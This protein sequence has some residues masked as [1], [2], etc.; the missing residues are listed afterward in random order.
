M[1]IA[2]DGPAGAGKSTLARWLAEKLNYI[3]IDTGAMYRALTWEALRKEIDIHNAAIL[4]ELAR[5]TDIH[6]T[7]DSRSQR[8]ICN[9]IDVTEQIRSPE[10]N[11]AV[12]QVAAH[13]EVRQLMVSKQQQMAQAVAVVMDGRDIG[14]CVLPDANY[15]F[16]ITASI[17]E[18]TRR[19]AAELKSSGYEVNEQ[20]IS[21]EIQNRDYNDTHR[22]TGALK[23]LEDSIIVDTSN[24]TI[25]EALNTLLEIIGR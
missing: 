1:K 12:S 22:T 3:Y 13:A 25:E 14:E 15:K 2:I 10:V 17:E 8:V 6:F 19:R 7:I 23:V 11:S 20:N 18:R 5:T 9:G 24:L 4:A 16:Y 21:Q